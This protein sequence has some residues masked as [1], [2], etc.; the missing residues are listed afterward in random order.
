MITVITRGVLSLGLIAIAVLM[1]IAAYQ[2]G[3]YST[4]TIIVT[5]VVNLVLL[6]SAYLL[7]MDAVKAARSNESG[8]VV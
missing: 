4:N 7:A 3:G 8:G 1:D 2:N 6:V 5:I